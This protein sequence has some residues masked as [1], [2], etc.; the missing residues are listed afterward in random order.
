MP[1]RRTLLGAGARSLITL[2][3]CTY[4]PTGG[5][6]AAPTTSLPEQL[7]GTRN[8][9]Y[10]FCWLRDATL[11]LLELMD[12]GF[13]DEAQ[14]WREW[15][16]RA[17]AGS[18]E[19]V[20]IM[21][22]IA[23]ERRLTEWEVPWLPGYEGS[24]P[25]RIGNAAHG[26]LQLDVFGE[27]MDALHQ[28]RC[29]GIAASES[30]WALQQA[31]LAHLERVWTEPDEGLGSCAVGAGTSPIP[32]SW[33]G[34]PSIGRS[35]ARRSSLSQVRSTAGGR[36]RWLFTPTSAGAA[37]TRARKLRSVL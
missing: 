24:A 15:L 20:Q 11:I 12:S 33:R 9:D 37:S 4:W 27:V 7:G 28:A 35:R 36:S 17:V 22:G 5:I 13:Y 3:A 8:W 21:Y 2:K 26:Q 32:R 31:F 23:G 29:N 18:P 25:V 34:S 19:Q 14:E 10:R 30:G 1:A 16:L 6:V